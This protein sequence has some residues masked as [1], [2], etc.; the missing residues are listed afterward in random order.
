ME[1]RTVPIDLSMATCLF[2]CPCPIRNALVQGTAALPPGVSISL[3]QFDAISEWDIFDYLG[4]REKD[5]PDDMPELKAACKLL[6]VNQFKYLLPIGVLM[7]WNLLGGV[8]NISYGTAP[9]V[10][11]S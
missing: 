2:T 4:D 10:R 11:R 6:H 3:E 1:S 9:Q 8:S 5:I 7:Y